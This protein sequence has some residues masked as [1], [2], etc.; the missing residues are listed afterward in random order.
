MRKSSSPKTTA[1]AS[2][3]GTGLTSKKISPV[4]VK[5]TA[6]KKGVEATSF[7]LSNEVLKTKKVKAVTPKT[8]KVEKTVAKKATKSPVA[9]KV[10][11][12]KVVQVDTVSDLLKQVEHATTPLRIVMT[13]AEAYPFAKSGGLADVCASLP[14]ALAERG[15]TV[16]VIMPYYPQI[17][18]DLCAKTKLRLP[19]M[20][21]PFGSWEEWCA[22]RQTQIS[23]NLTFYFIEYNRYYD[24]PKLYDFNN[25]E[26][27]DN[28]ARYI[29]FCRA[30]M[31]TMKY[32][33]LRPDIIHAHDWHA[34]LCCVYLISDLYKNEPSFRGTRSVL[35][36]HNLGYQ[37]NFDKSNLWLS[38]LGWEYFNHLCLEFNDRLNFL[39]GGL[40]TADMVSTVSPTYAEEILTPEHAFSLDGVLRHCASRG[41]LRG[42]LNGIDAKDWNPLHD[43]FLPANYTADAL[44]GKAICKAYLQKEMHLDVDPSK[45]IIGVVSRLAS[46][47]GIDIFLSSIDSILAQNRAQ[48]VML[49]SGDPGLHSWMDHYARTYPGRFADFIGFSNKLSH[50]IEAGSDFFAM[51]SRYEP[52]GLNQMY[53]MIYGT[54]PIV[55]S[56][57]GLADTVINFEYKNT[58]VA[59]GFKFNDLNTDALRQTLWWA[60]DTY[61]RFPEAIAQLQQNGMHTDFSWNKTAIEYES[62]YDTALH[63]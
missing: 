53:S 55:R 45:P 41:R 49:G 34:A 7:E 6:S 58:D 37:G 5:K 10:K 2:K 21:V 17:M 16:S 62:L 54:L 30:A 48:I 51:P 26:Y 43:L 13:T 38:G 1:P 52:C 19:S 46:Q 59:T 24:R 60:I 23:P 9:S 36:I 40:L 39:K 3:K 18:K 28:A 20:K 33:S 14:A 32:L 50:L 22:V 11:T 4:H 63:K 8:S 12:P 57:G 42:I 15:H 25:V 56:T 61:E 27:G 44:E 47:K 35:T 31:E 29:F